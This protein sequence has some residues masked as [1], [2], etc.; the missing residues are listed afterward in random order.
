MGDEPSVM[1]EDYDESSVMVGSIMGSVMLGSIMENY[2]EERSYQELNPDE[3]VEDVDVQSHNDDLSVLSMGEAQDLVRE[4]T[5]HHADKS[6]QSATTP[7]SPNRV[8]SS[9][10]PPLK[11]LSLL[12]NASWSSGVMKELNDLYDEEESLSESPIGFVSFDSPP[13]QSVEQPLDSPSFTAPT[14]QSYQDS[15]ED[16][17]EIFYNADA[18]LNDDEDI[19]CGLENQN[20]TIGLSGVPALISTSECSARSVAAVTVPWKRSAQKSSI[21]FVFDCVEKLAEVLY[22]W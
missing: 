8:P 6:G 3:D 16:G 4:D 13:K 22:G 7:L 14:L 20:L 2:D 1:T 5:T 12:S 9:P 19:L 15:T 11:R 18:E 21:V 17:D 10:T